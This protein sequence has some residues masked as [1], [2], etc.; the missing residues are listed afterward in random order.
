MLPYIQIEEI[1]KRVLE[2][3]PID[4]SEIHADIQDKIKLTLQA[5]LSKLDLVSREE[6]DIQTHVLSKTRE[7]VECLEKQ[8][9]ELINT[10][11]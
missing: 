2:A 3:L 11:S 8:V 1:T 4:F 6:F 10:K 7:K 9:Q 5:T